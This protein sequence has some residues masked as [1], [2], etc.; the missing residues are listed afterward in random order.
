MA[1]S[2]TVLAWKIAW[3]EELGGL[4]SLGSRKSQTQLS[5]KRVQGSEMWTQLSMCPYSE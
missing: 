2:S 5:K 1:T 4:Q 3:T